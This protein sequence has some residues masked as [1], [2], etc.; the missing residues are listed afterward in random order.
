MPVSVK[1]IQ[2]PAP[3]C[4]IGRD[5]TSSETAVAPKRRLPQT[6]CCRLQAASSFQDDCRPTPHM[7]PAPA[8]ASRFVCNTSSKE[9]KRTSS[10]FKSNKRARTHTH[11]ATPTA[12]NKLLFFSLTV[13]SCLFPP[14]SLFPC[15][16]EGYT[17]S[18][19]D[20]SECP[21]LPSVALALVIQEA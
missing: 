11:T 6:S 1:G 13:P 19:A 17:I 21:S 18:T 10:S 16:W 9:T 5:P 7:Q 2:C 12:S 20:G 14:S 8:R 4:A 3:S 15:T